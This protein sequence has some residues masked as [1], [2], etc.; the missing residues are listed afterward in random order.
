MPQWVKELS[1]GVIPRDDGKVEG[2]SY[3]R[4][5]CSNCVCMHT[6]KLNNTI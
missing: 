3:T 5:T 6:H 2:E 1:L 4:G